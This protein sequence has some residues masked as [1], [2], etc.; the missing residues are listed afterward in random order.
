LVVETAVVEQV[1][2][3]LLLALPVVEVLLKLL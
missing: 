2:T 1:D 3:E